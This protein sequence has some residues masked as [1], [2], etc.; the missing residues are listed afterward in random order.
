MMTN[1]PNIEGAEDDVPL[2]R[3]QIIELNNIP[4]PYAKNTLQ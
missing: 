2:L 3:D 1:K 4:E